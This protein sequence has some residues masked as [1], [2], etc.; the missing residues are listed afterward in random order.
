MVL[1]HGRQICGSIVSGRSTRDVLNLVHGLEEKGT[2]LRVLEPEVT[3]VGS[4][5]RKVNTMLGWVGD[6]EPKFI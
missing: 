5:G 6:V 3:T 4:I 2:L 1:P